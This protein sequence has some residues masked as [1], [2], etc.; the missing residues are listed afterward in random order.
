MRI[1]IVDDDEIVLDML[2][3]TLEMDGH[4]VLRAGNGTEALDVLSREDVRMVISDWMM[5]GVNGIELVKRIR[6]HDTDRYI[7][8]I[9]LTSRTDKTDAAEGLDAGAD[10]FIS[11]PFDPVEMRLR[12]KAGERLLSLESHQVTIF[13][14]AKL[15]DV[16]D[17][18]T[19][20]HL[21]RLREYSR[22]LALHIM[23]I[24]QMR[25]KLSPDY[26]DMIYLT[27][28]LHDIGKVGIPDCVL[29]K[30]ERLDDTEFTVMKTH[31][32]LGGETFSAAL[33]QFHEA[34]YLRM[35][36]EIAL[37]HHERYDGHGYPNGK[38]G[39]EIP[40]CARIVSVA[41]VYDALISKRVY[42]Q[43]FSHEIARSIIIEGIGTQFDP[44]VVDAFIA[45]ETEIRGIATRLADEAR[46]SAYQSVIDKKAA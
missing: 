2:S 13:A 39:N 9:L 18:E 37:N 15:T 27:S 11:K 26:A 29:L 10:D 8:T 35:A 3:A 38:K 43:A 16:R 41:D 28:P 23:N 20:M 5:P 14:L 31:T 6:A 12:I 33:E 1:L 40:L 24:P 44:M 34:G 25:G 17:N 45:R 36:Y 4:Q 22:L 46:A 32:T 42:K 30:P 7:Y 19:G 21:E